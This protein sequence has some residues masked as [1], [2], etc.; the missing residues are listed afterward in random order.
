MGWDIRARVD[1]VDR[2]VIR[3]LSQAHCERIHFGV[4]AGTD[5][6][7]KVLQKGITVEQAK[8]AFRLANEAGISTLAYFMIGS[9]GETRDDILETVRLA[10]E[11]RPD[12][13]HITIVTPFPATE[14]YQRGLAEGVWKEDFWREFAEEPTASFRPFHW[15][16]ELS[17]SELQKLLEYA[18]KSFYARPSYVVREL[19]KVR[20]WHELVRKVKAGL[21]VLRI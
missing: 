1:S 16:T 3:K 9:P 15:E 5:K 2:E 12:F 18:Y 8:N 6:I 20:S 4:E 17:E 14:I 21:K 19:V 7:L 10:G 13:V 11:L